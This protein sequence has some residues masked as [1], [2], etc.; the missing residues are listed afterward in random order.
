ML[1]DYEEDKINFL[2][3]KIVDVYNGVYKIKIDQGKVITAKKE[4]SLLIKPIVGDIIKVYK[5][6]DNF[7]ISNII[8]RESEEMEFELKENTLIKAKNLKFEA[9]SLNSTIENIKS[10]FSIFDLSGMI[11]NLKSNTLKTTTNKTENINIELINKSDRSYKYINE[12]EEVQCRNSRELIEENKI[13]HSKNL[14]L[15][16]KEQIK[17]DGELINLA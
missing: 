9:F 16:A 5:H 3:G 13:V 1:Y 15:N 17:I 10:F 4:F 14:V 11:L 6:N 7:Y 12:F 8:H 2:S